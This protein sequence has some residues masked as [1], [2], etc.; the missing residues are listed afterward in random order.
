MTVQSLPALATPRPAAAKAQAFTSP[1]D[2][3]TFGPSR[4]GDIEGIYNRSSLTQGKREAVQLAGVGVMMTSI[5]VGAALQS[6]WSP[7]IMIGGMFAGL[8]IM[9]AGQ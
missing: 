4:S 8:A 7:A 3:D 6:S 5:L 1:A 9:A 2:L